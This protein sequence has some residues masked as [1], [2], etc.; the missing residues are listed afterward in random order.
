MFDSYG[1]THLLSKK[2]RARRGDLLISDLM[3]WTERYPFLENAL[4][5]KLVIPDWSEFCAAVERIYLS[6]LGD[7][8]GDVAQY[9]PQ[10]AKVSPDK[11][12]L[13]V[14][15]KDGQR[16]SL[17]D[18]KEDFCIQSCSKPITYC[19]AVE[20]SSAEE[21]HAHVGRE[22]SGKNFNELVMDKNNL[23]HNP[24]INAGAIMTCS[25]VK[26]EMTIADRFSFVCNRWKVSRVWFNY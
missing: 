23:P 16:L 22:P 13:C 10:L 9:I 19:I 7:R 2:D 11:F 24:L 14:T 4:G 20:N 8:A 1:L 5:G 21:V 18:A 6:C 15:S 3:D 17:G 12:G 25:L 26:P